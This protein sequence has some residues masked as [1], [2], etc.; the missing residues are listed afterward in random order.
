MLY[1]PDFIEKG[2]TIYILSI[3]R[4]VD[5]EELALSIDFFEKN[6]L[7]VILG[8]TIGTSDYQ[9]SDTDSNRAKDFQF[10]LDHPEVKAIFFA[11]GGYGAIRVIDR[12]DWTKFVK[13]PKW[14]CG[15]SDVTVV[16]NRVNQF[17]GIQSLHCPMPITFKENTANALNSMMKAIEGAYPSIS[18]PAHPLNTG[19]E[20]HGEI[21]GGNL[22]IL[23]SLLGTHNGFQANN[24]ILFV[25]DLDEYLYH[26]DR[27]MMSIKLAGKLK[28]VSAILVGG[29]TEMKDN[30]TPFG[31]SAEEIILEHALEFQIPVF[32][33]IPA[34]HLADNRP[35]ILGAEVM[36]ST[37]GNMVTVQYKNSRTQ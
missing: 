20:A 8:K 19:I 16:H 37:E 14:L 6:G 18:F 4:K 29:M 27:M 13:K 1:I 7:K 3:S 33:G 15:F 10:A 22:S 36:L 35:L 28:G 12:V 23:Y 34:G 21:I 24:R 5:Q 11:R 2:D 9:F 17:Y 30:I 31:K 32:F 25:E 26:V